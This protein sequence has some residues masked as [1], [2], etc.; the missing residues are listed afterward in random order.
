ME[1]HDPYRS[2]LADDPVRIIQD[3][4]SPGFPRVERRIERIPG[5]WGR[6]TNGPHRS[7]ECLAPDD[8]AVVPHRQRTRDGRSPG[9]GLP[10]FAQTETIEFMNLGEVPVCPGDSFDPRRVDYLM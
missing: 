9:S 7:L 2:K 10:L 3:S 8:L 1:K 5:T 6:G 4:H